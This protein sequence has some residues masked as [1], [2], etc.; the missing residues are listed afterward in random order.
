MVVEA[1][2]NRETELKLAVRAEDMAKLRSCPAVA[3]RAKGKAG[4][5]TLE[6]TYYDTADRRLAG[7][8]VTLR[9]RKVGNQFL[10]T[11]KGAPERGE[12][13]RAEWEHPVAGPAPDLSAI[14]S[15]EALDLLGSVGAAE[16]QPLFTTLIQ[17]TVRVVTMG[18]GETASRIE[19]AFDSGEIRSPDGASIPVS[20]VELELLEGSAAALYD[21]ALELAQAAPLRLD[22]RTKAE[23]GYALADGTVD[24]VIKAGK[25]ELDRDT[26][27]EGALARILR[28]C[29]GHM[30]ANEAVT[31]IGEDPEGVHQM[32]VA[33]R[34]LRS[35]LAL[36]KHFIPADSYAWL[37]GEVK[38]LGGSLGPARDWDVFLDELL[39]PVKES[40]HRADGHGKPLQE[41]IDALAAAARARRDRAYEG[42]R[43]AIRSERYTSFLLK[44]GAWVE[45]RG[46]RDQPVSEHSAR[47]FDPVE[48]LADHLLSRR[49]KKARRAGHGFASLSVTERHELRI[50][51]KKLRYAAEFFRSL[52]DDKPARRYIQDLSAFQDALGHLNDVATATR[53]L[54]ELHDDGSRPEPGEPRAAGIVIGWHA[55]GV[56]ESEPAL[57]DLWKEFADAKAFWSKPDREG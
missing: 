27:V 10:Q 31:L 39:E 48:D 46:W 1:E 18:E 50:A 2:S 25:L 43:E 56:A 14:E 51:L 15:Q 35:A 41:D 8:L 21:L 38:W 55:R 17:R 23:R 54:H 20:E 32:R 26:T 29:I 33:L 28:S 42:V 30:L 6:S 3:S 16:L 7:R 45:S 52:Y 19:V 49:A 57:R 12:L 5:K 9:V 4:T 22:P 44:F 11:V 13:G 34:R 37:V 47:L 24:K 53:L 40:F 36:F